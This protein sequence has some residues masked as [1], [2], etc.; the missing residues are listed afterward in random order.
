[1]PHA[2]SC[3]ILPHRL[4]PLSRAPCRR[5]RAPDTCSESYVRPYVEIEEVALLPPLITRPHAAP[6]SRPSPPLALPALSHD[7]PLVSS[8]LS[9][10]YSPVLSHDRMI[11]DCCPAAGRCTRAPHARTCLARAYKYVRRYDR[12]ST[13]ARSDAVRTLAGTASL[14]PDALMSRKERLDC[15]LTSDLFR[16]VDRQRVKSR[17][18]VESHWTLHQ[19]AT[20]AAPTWG[21]RGPWGLGLLRKLLRGLL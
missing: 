12:T 5:D 19:I 6:S 9:R 7:H 1:M 3:L 4:I 11:M 15:V 16:L 17:R 21:T 13:Y 18:L 10:T 14:M 2:S 8:G 20:K